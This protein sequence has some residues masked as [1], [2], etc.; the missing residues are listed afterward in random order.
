MSTTLAKHGT[1]SNITM[2]EKSFLWLIGYF[3]CQHQQHRQIIFFLCL[4][5]NYTSFRFPRITPCSLIIINDAACV[6]I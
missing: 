5:I 3:I 6:Y 2:L 1:T 4:D